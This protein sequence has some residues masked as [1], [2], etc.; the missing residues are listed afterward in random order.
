MIR[1]F[2]L[3]VMRPAPGERMAIRPHCTRG[4]EVLLWPG[5]AT[6]IPPNAPTG[7]HY[8]SLARGRRQNMYGRGLTGA[9]LLLM[10]ALATNNAFAAPPPPCRN[11]G[12]YDGWLASFERE[13]A[14][15]GISQRAI[16]RC[17]AFACL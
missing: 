14:A 12:S 8:L 11:T 5:G 7:N 15:Q 1:E 6:G 13:A 3:I 16:C 10:S 17:C 4:A 9:A 2:R